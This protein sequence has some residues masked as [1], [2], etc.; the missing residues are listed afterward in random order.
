MGKNKASEPE[1]VKKD[2]PVK[3]VVHQN[4]IQ[5]LVINAK[6]ELWLIGAQD[7]FSTSAEDLFWF[8]PGGSIEGEETVLQ[9]AQ[10]VIDREIGLSHNEVRFGPIVWFGE[11]EYQ[12]MN[13]VTKC[14]QQFIVIY[15]E[16]SCITLQQ[17]QIAKKLPVVKTKWFTYD[18]IVASESIAPIGLKRNIKDVLEQKHPSSPIKIPLRTN[19]KQYYF[20]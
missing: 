20:L 14:S 8:T 3:K 7:P 15:T 1:Y 6:K 17:A 19:A 12:L 2:Y 9:A 5:L 18:E 4:L 10:R 16:Q 13:T 11:F